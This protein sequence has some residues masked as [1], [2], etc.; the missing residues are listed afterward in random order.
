[1]ARSSWE[2]AVMAWEMLRSTWGLD[3]RK[4][5]PSLERWVPLD[6]LPG[7]GLFLTCAYFAGMLGGDRWAR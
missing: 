1:M 4:W 2:T 5:C 6:F 3:D 7:E